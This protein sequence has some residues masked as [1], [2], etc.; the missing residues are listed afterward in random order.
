MVVPAFPAINFSISP[1]SLA[2]ISFA[3]PF[4]QS[5][6]VVVAMHATSGTPYISNNVP[7]VP[8]PVARAHAY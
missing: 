8:L 5:D 3:L 1:N 6:T 7:V 4:K 2:K